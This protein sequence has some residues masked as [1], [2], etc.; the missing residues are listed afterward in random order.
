MISELAV[1]LLPRRQD[2][3]K[4]GRPTTERRVV[5]ERR[6]VARMYFST[7]TTEKAGSMTRKY[8]TAHFTLMGTFVPRDNLWT[9]TSRVTTRRSTL[10]PLSIDWMTSDGRVPWNPRAS[11]TEDHHRWY[12]RHHLHRRCKDEHGYEKGIRKDVPMLRIIS[13]ASIIM[14]SPF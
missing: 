9:G 1:D 10:T 5:W 6:L 14:G 3:V 2:L 12:F 7:S 4:V 8:T 13:T 11:Q